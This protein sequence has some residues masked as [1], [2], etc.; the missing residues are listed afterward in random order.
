MS[1]L[2][3]AAIRFTDD[4]PAMRRFLETLGLAASTS[5]GTGMDVLRAGAG[6]VW[7]HRATG[8][9]IGAP[10]GCTQLTGRTADVDGLH[11]ALE[12]AGYETTVIDESYARVVEVTD[13][14]KAILSFNGQGDGYGATEHE[15][16]PDERVAVSLCRFT[17]PQGPYGEFAEA[18]GLQRQGEP[19]EWYV[20]YSAGGGI[21]GLHHD[22]GS[23][24]LPGAELGG[25]VLIGLNTS[26]PLEDIQQRLRDGG[27]PV[28][29]IVREDFGSFVETTDPDGRPLQIHAAD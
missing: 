5:Y 3:L 18:L 2:T 15:A 19:N 14:S 17:D 21:L 7:L 28:G 9:A 13:P 22:D 23:H 6:E 24:D 11:S 10:A 20:P 25:A 26:I 1:T 4:I 8:S 12:A 29:E 16:A 27:Y